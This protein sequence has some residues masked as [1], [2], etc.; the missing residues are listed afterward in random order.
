[1]KTAKRIEMPFGLMTRVGP[2]YHVL[3]GNQ[4]PSEEG[5]IFGCCADHSKVL[6]AFAAPV[7]QQKGSFSMPSKRK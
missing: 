7:M 6:A 3:D 1:M 4:I 2:K 5:T